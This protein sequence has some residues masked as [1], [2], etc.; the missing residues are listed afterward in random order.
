MKTIFNCVRIIVL[1]AN[2]NVFSAGHDLD[3]MSKN[4][5]KFHTELFSTC[6]AVMR[7]IRLSSVPVIAQVAGP[8]VAAGC[9]LVR[10]SLIRLI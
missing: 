4:N 8:A 10:T 6:S 2:G 5:S 7:A 9:Q 3:E 1:K